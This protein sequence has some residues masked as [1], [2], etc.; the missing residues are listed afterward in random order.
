M[1]KT[2]S[3]LFLLLFL[4]CST[5]NSIDNF[6]DA[7]KNDSNVLA[8][9]VPHFMLTMVSNVSPEMK[10]M[11][12]NTK[13]L[14]FMRFASTTP[15]RT[16]FLNKKMNNLVGSSFIEVYRKNDDLK[17][18]VVSVREKR[19]TVKE[20]LVYKNNNTTGSFLYFNGN[21]DPLKVREL[22]KSEQFETLGEGLINQFGMSTPGIS[23]TTKEN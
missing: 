23:P 2:L 4:S 5:Y 22:A 12:G 21:F 17:R 13:D 3:A 19:N 9:R 15:A 14:R 10:A 18:S 7:H 16:Q 1:K 8:V 20:I 6:Y 11:I